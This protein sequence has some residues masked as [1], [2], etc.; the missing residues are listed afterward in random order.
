[1]DF[2]SLK[3]KRDRVISM[4]ERGDIVGVYDVKS[5]GCCVLFECNPELA[6]MIIALWNNRYGMQGENPL[7]NNYQ[8]N[9]Q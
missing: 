1:M 3:L 7:S 6:D 8:L 2:K 9:N 5:D 4:T